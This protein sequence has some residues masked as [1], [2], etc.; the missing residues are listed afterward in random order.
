MQDVTEIYQEFRT[1]HGVG[2]KNTGRNDD[3]TECDLAKIIKKK[4]I[5]VNVRTKTNVEA[6]T[7][8]NR[9]SFG[10]R[11]VQRWGHVVFRSKYVRSGR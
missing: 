3:R 6:R 2:K 8:L 9:N 5:P 10:E 7:P 1:P 11:I 4:P